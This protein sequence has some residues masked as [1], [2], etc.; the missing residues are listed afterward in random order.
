MDVPNKKELRLFI[1]SCTKQN[2]LQINQKTLYGMLKDIDEKIEDIK[3]MNENDL[4]IVKYTD[5]KNQIIESNVELI[6]IEDKLLG[7]CLLKNIE[8]ETNMLGNIL[9]LEIKR[10]V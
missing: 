9:Q 5:D 7:T 6:C 3:N 1:H 4:L 8:D 2:E 10:G